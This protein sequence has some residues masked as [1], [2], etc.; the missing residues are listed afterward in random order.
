MPIGAGSDPLAAEA[1]P[2]IPDE[3]VLSPPEE[4]DGPATAAAATGTGSQEGDAP[5]DAGMPG[6]LVGEVN[7][8]PRLAWVGRT[9][10]TR[11]S[12]TPTTKTGRTA[13]L[14]PPKAH[15]QV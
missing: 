10:R 11:R 8:R 14:A 1:G 9:P 15:S 4:R 5:E 12:T 6:S 2:P 3:G 13:L 7:E